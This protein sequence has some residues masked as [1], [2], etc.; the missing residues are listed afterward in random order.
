MFP[1]LTFSTL[2]FH[3]CP[4]CCSEKRRFSRPHFLQEASGC[5]L[6]SS[7]HVHTSFLIAR[8]RERC[9]RRLAPGHLLWYHRCGV[10][11][12]AIGEAAGNLCN[13]P[14]PRLLTECEL[15]RSLIVVGIPVG[16]N[17]LK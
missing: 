17:G 10:I 11:Q 14:G 3:S 7:C 15:E 4:V 12:A 13:L 9:F 16:S 2:D 1:C 5:P 6:A 8:F